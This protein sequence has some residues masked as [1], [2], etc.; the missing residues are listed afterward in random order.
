MA[1]V[2]YR[3]A[4]GS[5]VDVKDALLTD[6]RVFLENEITSP[7]IQDTIRQMMY[8][9]KLDD[10]AEI[11]LYI[12]SP[13]GDVY[14]G[15]ALYDFIANMKSPIKTVCMGSAASMGAILFLAVDRRLMLKHSRLMIHD[16]SYGGGSFAGMKPHEIQQEVDSLNECK[17]T[18]VEI[19]AEKTG[20]SMEEIGKLT[21][22][23]AFFTP[24]EA[25]EFGLATGIYEGV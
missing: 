16:P 20:K 21:E 19:I 9:E 2:M 7:L 4:K 5:L 18:L 6:R 14:S 24:K 22:R 3:S 10:T 1:N 17:K 25:I 13:G 11:T 15:L 23:D 8:L 12:N